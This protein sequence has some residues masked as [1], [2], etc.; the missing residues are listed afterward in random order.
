M[1]ELIG[2][3]AGKLWDILKKK[4]EMSIAQLPKTLKE[5]DAV[6]F[7]ALGWLA[8]EGKVSYR[9]QGNR[10]FVKLSD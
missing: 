9:T 6:V 2:R 7:Q 1:Q 5:K 8:R 10:T 4:D 3:T